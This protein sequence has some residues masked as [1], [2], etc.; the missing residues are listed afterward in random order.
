[1]LRVSKKKAV[2][3][4]G[5]ISTI[6]IAVA[7]HLGKEPFLNWLRPYR[8]LPG[9]WIFVGTDP[10]DRRGVYSFGNVYKELRFERGPKLLV[11]LGAHRRDPK[12]PLDHY[13]KVKVSLDGSVLLVYSNERFPETCRIVFEGADVL[14]LEDIAGTTAAVYR[15]LDTEGP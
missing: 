5:V 9:D 13:R 1:M 12:K 10:P 14:R 11:R 8:F 6:V 7:V 2:I 15:R 4:V 3:A